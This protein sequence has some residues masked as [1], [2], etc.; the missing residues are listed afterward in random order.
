MLSFYIQGVSIS[1]SAHLYPFQVG[2]STYLAAAGVLQGQPVTE[3][4]LVF[5]AVA[6]DPQDTD[7]Y[8]R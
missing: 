2:N 3:T 5:E 7:Y 6:V 1:A 8:D 4:S